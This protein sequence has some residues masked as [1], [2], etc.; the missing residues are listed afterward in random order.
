VRL[1]LPYPRGLRPGEECPFRLG[2]LHPEEKRDA[3]KYGSETVTFA[4]RHSIPFVLLPPAARG[5]D[6]RAAFSSFLSTLSRLLEL[7]ARYAVR[8]AIEP[9]IEAA[10]L[11]S[12]KEV[13]TCL[14]EFEGAPLDL[15]PRA[16]GEEK[17][18]W[19]RLAGRLAGVTVPLPACIEAAAFE[20]AGWKPFRPLLD[21]SP[22]WLLDFPPGTA[23]D[24]LRA[25]RELLEAL[26][27]GPEKDPFV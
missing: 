14:E 20:A 27:R 22:I 7:A 12:G 9:A 17:P 4:E 2:S 15:W 1:F 21:A 25:G 18:A 8:L 23:P 6:S 5:G 10:R 19:E 3:L 13:E 11:P 26:A 16:E 24:R